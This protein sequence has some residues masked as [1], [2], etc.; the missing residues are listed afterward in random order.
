M[1]RANKVKA[2]SS[3]RDHADDQYEQLDSSQVA[4]DDDDGCDNDGNEDRELENNKKVGSNENEAREVDSD[5][6]D[7][8]EFA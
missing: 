5:E 4:Y 2:N 3:E 7:N 1:K 6:N 8:F